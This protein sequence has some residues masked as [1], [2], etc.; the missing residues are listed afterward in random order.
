MGTEFNPAPSPSDPLATVRSI[1]LNKI[2][3]NFTTTRWEYHVHVHGAVP[4]KG[5]PARGSVWPLGASRP[6][7]GMLPWCFLTVGV[8]QLSHPSAL[9]QS[10]SSSD[11][12]WWW[13]S[14]VPYASKVNP[15]HAHKSVLFFVHVPKTGGTSMIALLSRIGEQRKPQMC[16][17]RCMEDLN[18][19]RWCDTNLTCPSGNGIQAGLSNLLVGHMSYLKYTVRSVRLPPWSRC[20]GL[21]PRLGRAVALC[22]P[23]AA[24][25]LTPHT[26]WPTAS[27]YRC[28]LSTAWSC[29]G[30]PYGGW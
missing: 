13:T 2:S 28:R 17:R 27:T 22:L 5:R 18:C 21:A 24:V 16:V 3:P 23:H 11:A 1:G 10:N 6:G 4:K 20:G 15:P 25:H 7:E 19:C 30:V 9:I 14:T 12:A 29:C 8:P 26:R